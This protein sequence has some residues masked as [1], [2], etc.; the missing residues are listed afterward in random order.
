MQRIFATA[1][2]CLLSLLVPSSALYAQCAGCSWSGICQ[3]GPL[4][5][6]YASCGYMGGWCVASGSCGG[7]ATSLSPSGSSLDV[8]TRIDLAAL[9]SGRTVTRDCRGYIAQ[10]LYSEAVIRS[11][12]ELTKHIEV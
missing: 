8:A 10:R 9:S 1:V 6:G 12:Q 4:A 2:L 11:L 3:Y 7:F 5:D